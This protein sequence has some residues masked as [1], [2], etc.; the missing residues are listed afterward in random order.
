MNFK[1]SLTVGVNGGNLL[2][3]GAGFSADCL[4]FSATEIGAASPLLEFFNSALSYSYSELQLAADDY[5]DKFG[6]ISLFKII[7]DKYS[8][9]KRT[10]AVD[11]ILSYPWSRIYTT[12][13][14]NVIEQSLT[15]QKILH[16]CAN[17]TESPFDVFKHHPQ[18]QIIVH[19]HGAMQKWDFKSFIDSCVLERKS[20]LTISSSS[21]WAAQLREDYARATGVFFVGFSN[22]DFYLAEQLFSVSASK[23]KVFFIN[24]E[25]SGM[26]RELQA[27][28]RSFGTSFSIGKEA[29]ASQVAECLRV[30]APPILETH[31]FEKHTLLKA[32]EER[33]SVIEQEAFMIR[34]KTNEAL[35]FHDIIDQS[36]S[37]RAHRMQCDTIVEFLKKEKAV[38]MV[39]GGICSGKSQIIDECVLRLLTE[40]SVVFVLRSKFYDLVEEARRISEAHPTAI[41]VIDDCFS[42]RGDL[43]KI[44]KYFNNAQNRMLLSSRTLAHDSEEDLRTQLQEDAEYR[45]FDS[46]ILNYDE[47]IE[48][49]SCTDRIAGWGAQVSG[50]SQK[51]RILERGHNS[52]LSGFLLGLFSAP[53]IRCRFLTEIDVIR[54]SGDNA[55]R[56]L[57]L[58]L[59]LQ[60]IGER[61]PEHVLSG[62]LGQDSIQ[63]FKRNKATSSFVSYNAGKRGFDVIPSVNARESL[64]QFFDPRLVT[65][66]IVEAVRNIEH[67]RYQPAFNR[68]FVEFMRYTQLKQVVTSFEQQDRFFDRL[69]EIWFCNRHVLFK[70]QWSMAMRDHQEWGRAWQYLEDA[71]GQARELHDFTT[72]HLDDQKAGLLLDS[73]AIGQKSSFYLLRFKEFAEIL[74]RAIRAAPVTSHNYQTII[75]SV[76]AFSEKALAALD[77]SHKP[78]MSASATAIVQQIDKKLG[79]QPEGF[80]K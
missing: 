62:L 43:V 18:S 24:R 23:D 44:L 74:T 72:Y 8:V 32:S 68:V 9:S 56:A 50:I 27:R 78:L 11:D 31:S 7:S 80:I 61:V 28:Q 6:E 75:Q 14:D 39:I 3:C 34:G 22:S 40:G 38:A 69:S 63:I 4:N 48:L 73:V 15:D 10:K 71:Y 30:G 67:V 16:C 41:I 1:D 42:L 51:R 54:I 35:L 49:I 21:N 79:G 46:E 13:Y 2:F 45:I 26:D 60:N 36:H 53:H 52:R 33:A 12:N 5:I 25:N 64:K 66:I 19:L 59:Y 17:N 55:E 37:Y 70:L 77:A 20:Y 29:F 76:P 47:G 57:I 58:A 65:D